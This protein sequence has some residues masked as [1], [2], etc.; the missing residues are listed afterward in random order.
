MVEWEELPASLRVSNRFF[1]Q[2]VGGKLVQLGVGL[3]SLR[4]AAP[5]HGLPLDAEE[6]DELA[7]AEH[8]RW[9]RDQIADGWRLTAGPKDPDRKL[10]PL[11]VPW[12]EL[13]QVSREK[14][15]DSIRALPMMLAR[16][17]YQI[18]PEN[19]TS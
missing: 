1:A 6:L 9:M 5:P 12:E 2:S 14:D 8:D 11:L 18:E 17:G 4:S 3:T 16:I 7:Q 13:D 15:R 19:P 10:H